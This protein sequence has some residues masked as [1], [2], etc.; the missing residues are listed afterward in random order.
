MNIL[1]FDIEE[2]YLYRM[3]NN[4]A[5]AKDFSNID[6]YLGILLDVLDFR[7]I[8]ATFFCLGAIARYN[9][10]IIN[11]ICC[12]GHEIGCHSDKHQWL[13]ELS[14]KELRQDTKNA[15]DSLENLTGTKIKSYRAPA[16]S[17]TEKNIWILEILTENGI[18]RDSSLF[19]AVRDF[20]GFPTFPE[21][22]PIS[23]SFNNARIKEFPVAVTKIF[24]K[25][26][27][28]SGGGYFRLLPYL[29]INKAFNSND[30]NMAYL[31]VRDFDKE[32]KRY[33]SKRYFKDYYGINHAFNKFCMLTDDFEFVNIEKADELIHWENRPLIKL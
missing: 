22:G 18:E 33:L 21:N 19:P 10:E 3:R 9:P 31:H 15:I 24:G 8:R 25:K 14:Y 5:D 4:G 1:T 2:W 23:L 28:Y 27:A 20:G 11:K 6:R 30:Y 26:V 17:F 32:Q 16:F 13:T 7:G 29:F 12:R